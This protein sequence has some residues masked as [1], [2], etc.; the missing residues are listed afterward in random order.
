MNN[1][2]PTKVWYKITYPFP[3][4]NAA[5]VQP[6]KFKN[7]RMNEQFHPTH[8]DGCIYLSMLGLKLIDV[9]ER[10]PWH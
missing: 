4:V 10:G 7:L 6:L 9:S 8:Y 3:N 1:Y 5:T 2:V